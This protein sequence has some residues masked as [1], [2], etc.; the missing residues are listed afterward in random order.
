[1]KEA[2]LVVELFH[3]EGKRPPTSPNWDPISFPSEGR[4][5]PSDSDEMQSDNTHGVRIR[6]NLH[7]QM[8]Y[9]DWQTTYSKLCYDLWKIMRS[10]FKNQRSGVK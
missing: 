5:P 7:G 9:R 4:L 3:K 6:S 8:D 1:M 2:A 10:R